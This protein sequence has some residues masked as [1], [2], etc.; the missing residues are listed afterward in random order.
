MTWNDRIVPE[1]TIS[2]A[3]IPPAPMP[4]LIA[5]RATVNAAIRSSRVVRAV[6]SAPA[7]GCVHPA[8]RPA[9]AE[10]RNACHGCVTNASEP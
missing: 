9:T 6:I 4:A 3:T 5:T 8:P 10:P 1:A 2:P 7:A